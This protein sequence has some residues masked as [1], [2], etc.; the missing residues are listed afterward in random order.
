MD[1]NW[2]YTYNSRDV[3]AD[4]TVAYFHTYPCV[5]WKVFNATP[6]VVGVGAHYRCSLLGNASDGIESNAR[7]CGCLILIYPA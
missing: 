4:T 3:G 1:V 2:K 7:D 5:N 6:Y